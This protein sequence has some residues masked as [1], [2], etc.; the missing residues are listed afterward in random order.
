MDGNS[1]TEGQIATIAWLDG[2][3]SGLPG[4]VG[5][6]QVVRNRVLA[7]WHSGDWVAVVW[8]MIRS[9]E[10]FW[11]EPPDVRDPVFQKLMTAVSNV[12]AGTLADKLT[13]GALY[14]L[15]GDESHLLLP[16]LAQR[17]AQVGQLMFYK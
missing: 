3:T 4:M 1:Y 7:G 13:G 2:L 12:Y 6:A 10:R 16:V 9:R 15:V 8:N 5:I 11:G 14:Y 17:I